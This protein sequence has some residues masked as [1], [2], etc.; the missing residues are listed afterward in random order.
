MV[1]KRPENYRLRLFG[2]KNMLAYES[3]SFISVDFFF[4]FLEG[5]EP[6]EGN[7]LLRKA[8]QI[9]IKWRKYKNST[10]NGDVQIEINE[11]EESTKKLFKIFNAYLSLQRW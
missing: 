1:P 11:N 2:K 7:Y 8:G 3:V 6:D 5:I 10:V 4:F 9:R